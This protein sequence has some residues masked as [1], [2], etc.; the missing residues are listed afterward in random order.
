MHTHKQAQA[1]AYTHT[2]YDYTHAHAHALESL[3]HTA[4]HCNTLQHTTTTA[5]Q[6]PAHAPECLEPLL[7][8]DSSDS[9]GH[10]RV[11]VYDVRVCVC[12][13]VCV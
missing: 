12:A 7:A 5:L 1:H 11:T 2:H 10:P 4:T 13:Y 3:E 9:V 6:P 8:F